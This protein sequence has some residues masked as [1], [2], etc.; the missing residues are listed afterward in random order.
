MKGRRYLELEEIFQKRIPGRQLKIY[1]CDVQSLSMPTG[2]KD[3]SVLHDDGTVDG[4]GI[5]LMHSLLRQTIV[6]TCGGGAG[7]NTT[8]WLGKR[9]SFEGCIR[10]S[11]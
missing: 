11:M 5:S 10:I 1:K 7:E 4:A 2:E 8:R 3:V 6:F 9:R